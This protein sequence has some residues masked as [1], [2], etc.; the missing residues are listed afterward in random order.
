MTELGTE[1]G[2]FIDNIAIK[3]VGDGQ[4]HGGDFFLGG[5]E[6][7]FDFGFTGDGFWL[8]GAPGIKSVSGNVVASMNGFAYMTF[9]QGETAADP[10][11]VRTIL[12]SNLPDP[13]YAFARCITTSHIVPMRSFDG[14]TA[15][16]VN[17]GLDIW[18]TFRGDFSSRNQVFIQ[19]IDVLGHPQR[20][21]LPRVRLGRG[22]PR[23][24]DPRRSVVSDFGV[25][26][27][28]RDGTWFWDRQQYGVKESPVP[29]R[30]GRGIPRRD[31]G[32]L[33]REQ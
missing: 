2:S 20:G 21:D 24:L 14:D 12:Q 6:Q 9:G 29:E 23:L 3:G 22:D 27:G 17:E 19:T 7:N 13:S 11:P 28:V 15:Y 25:Y 1:L 4:V 10:I 30:A 31:S 5:R 26:Q 16:N 18:K 8:Q 33:R 32:P